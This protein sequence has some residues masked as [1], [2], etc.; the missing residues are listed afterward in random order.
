METTNTKIV[1]NLVADKAER[2][3]RKPKKE[4]IIPDHLRARIKPLTAEEREEFGITALD[5][6]WGKAGM[7]TIEALL[8]VHP[9]DYFAKSRTLRHRDL[10]FGISSEKKLRNFSE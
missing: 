3:S 2:L 10:N 1:L 5:E 6:A 8:T 9:D 4:D 7:M